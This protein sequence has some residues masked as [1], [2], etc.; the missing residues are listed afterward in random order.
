MCRDEIG[1]CAQIIDTNLETIVNANGRAYVIT[2]RERES[3][4]CPPIT[5]ASHEVLILKLEVTILMIHCMETYLEDQCT[6]GTPK[7][8]RH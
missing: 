6:K 2:Q 7:L 4:L 3:S 5:F 1:Q 8:G